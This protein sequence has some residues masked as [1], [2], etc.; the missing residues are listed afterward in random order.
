VP[1]RHGSRVNGVV[2][3]SQLGLDRFDEND[4]RLLEVLAGYAAVALENAHLYESLRREAEH[5]KAWLEFADE[6]SAAGSV[7]GMIDTVVVTVAR[8]LE[9]EQCSLWLEDEAIGD[10][11]CAASYGYL[12]EPT[13]SKIASTRVTR[14]AAEEFIRTAKTPFLM[15]A[16]ELHDWFFSDIEIAALKPVATAPLPAGH[17]VKGWITVRA[18]VAGLEHFTDD[19]LRLLDGLAYRASMAIQKAL[20]YREQRENA[21][22]ANALLDFGR[23][24]GP[25]ASEAGALEKAC[26]LVARMLRIPRAYVLLDEANSG[27][28]LIGASF[29]T[30]G[31]AGDARFP[32]DLMRGL[33]GRGSES[34]VLTHDEVMSVLASAGM[35]VTRTPSQLA[36]APLALSGNRLGC[37]I[38]AGGDDEHE[39][40]ELDLRLLAGMAH[41]AALL[42][43]R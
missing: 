37:L 39:F 41:Q 40:D 25:A 32:A 4:V 14:E 43:A 5:A 16:Q 35:D 7:E 12:E 6:V 9:A 29:G 13:G 18:P 34:F 27:D 23:E 26:E 17:G 19:R 8:L 10:F 22:V 24:I 36:V 31:S 38:A 15:N 3:L 33:L 2:F 42:I 11:V 30:N 1:L 21:H 20:L 28:V